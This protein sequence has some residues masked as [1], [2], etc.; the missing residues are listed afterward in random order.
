MIRKEAVVAQA[1]SLTWLCMDRVEGT[2]PR[3]SPR[4]LMCHIGYSRLGSVPS[5]KGQLSASVEN[6]H[7]GLWGC[8]GCMDGLALRGLAPR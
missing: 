3:Q 7:V 5:Y 8:G 4:T 1:M 2:G 6:W